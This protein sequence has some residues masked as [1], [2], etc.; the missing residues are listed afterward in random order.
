MSRMDT[1]ALDAA[2][3]RYRNAED[4]LRRARAVLT[5][6]VVAYIRSADERGAQAEA[7][8]RSG[9]SREQI[10]QIMQRADEAEAQAPAE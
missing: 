5:T 2:A 3:E 1:T 9:W 4:A 8:R 6:E 7:S 10:R